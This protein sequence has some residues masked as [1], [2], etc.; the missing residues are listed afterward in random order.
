M[1]TFPPAGVIAIRP[2]CD[3]R[4]FSPSKSE[5]GISGYDSL[6]GIERGFSLTPSD[7]GLF[8]ADE[9]LFISLDKP[10]GAGPCGSVGAAGSITEACPSSELDPGGTIFTESSGPACGRMDLS[11][12]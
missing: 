12:T 4:P 1:A 10:A 2:Y 11:V 9:P 3:E 5:Y 6:T 7:L 8:S